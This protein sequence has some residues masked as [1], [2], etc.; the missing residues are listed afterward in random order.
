[1][2]T[3]AGQLPKILVISTAVREGAV[4]AINGS[5]MNNKMEGVLILAQ[6]YFLLL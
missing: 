5:P 2:M 1:M 6:S 3:Q 4:T